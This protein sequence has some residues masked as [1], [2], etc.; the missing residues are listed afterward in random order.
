[1]TKKFPNLSR[2]KHIFPAMFNIGVSVTEL[3]LYGQKSL[4][5]AKKKKKSLKTKNLKTLYWCKVHFL[6][7]F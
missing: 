2:P 7:K 1:M 6:L 3:G 4:L 5:K